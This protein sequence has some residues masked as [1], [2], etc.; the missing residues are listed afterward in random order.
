MQGMINGSEPQR[1]PAPLDVA[2]LEARLLAYASAEVIAA[3]NRAGN[4]AQTSS[5]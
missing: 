3:A 2:L 4:A 1:L 5:T